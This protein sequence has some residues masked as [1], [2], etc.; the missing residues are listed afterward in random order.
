M[1]LVRQPIGVKGE[2]ER[3]G[4]PDGGMV[5]RQGCMAGRIQH[6]AV[7][8]RQGS[9]LE[10]TAQPSRHPAERRSIGIF[11]IPRR[12]ILVRLM[13]DGTHDGG[14]LCVDHGSIS[15]FIWCSHLPHTGIAL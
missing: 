9:V 10:M 6:F 15:L 8:L 1:D 7:P 5:E 14:I 2:T 13:K 11:I 12:Q 4:K 3:I